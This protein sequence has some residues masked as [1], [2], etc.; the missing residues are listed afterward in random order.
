M[1]KKKKR[2]RGL[3][4]HGFMSYYKSLVIKTMWWC[5]TYRQIEQWDRLDRQ[6]KMYTYTRNGKRNELLANTKPWMNFKIIMLSLRRHAKK[7]I[8]L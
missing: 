5:H 4:L 7:I 1:L 8:V 6:G 2:A 3:G